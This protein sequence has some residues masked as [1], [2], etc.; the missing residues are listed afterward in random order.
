MSQSLCFRWPVKF[1]KTLK[2]NQNVPIYYALAVIMNILS[3]MFDFY[4]R[5]NSCPGAALD[6]WL[7]VSGWCFWI[8]HP[9]HSEQSE[10][11]PYWA[12]QLPCS[13]GRGTSTPSAEKVPN[14]PEMQHPT[15]R[16]LLSLSWGSR[17]E[18]ICSHLGT[19][20]ASVHHPWAGDRKVTL[21]TERYSSSPA[22]DLHCP[23]EA[24]GSTARHSNIRLIFTFVTGWWVQRT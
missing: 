15:P 17:F 7:W 1:K 22:F 9:T 13:P 21:S 14:T 3:N 16:A 11:A 6:S 19:E 20:R 8:R 12:W 10:A 4:F 23:S 2:Q 18:P 5:K 24:L